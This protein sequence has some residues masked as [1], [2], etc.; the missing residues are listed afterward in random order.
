MMLVGCRGLMLAACVAVVGWLAAPAFGEPRFPPEYQNGDVTKV[1]KSLKANPKLLG[2]WLGAKEDRGTLL[3]CAVADDNVPMAKMLL[4]KGAKVHDAGDE[5]GFTPLHNAKSVAMAGLLISNKA[6]VNRPHVG[7]RTPLHTAILGGR[8][9]VAELLIKKGADVNAVGDHGSPLQYAADWA[10]SAEMVKLLLVNGAKTEI[11]GQQVPE[12]PLELAQNRKDKDS[13]PVKAIIELLS[14][15]ANGT[16]LASITVTD[17]GYTP[18]EFLHW[19]KHARTDK[20]TDILKQNPSLLTAADETGATALHQA[21]AA[22]STEL[23]AV[24]LAHK[25]NVNAQKK[26]G[27]TPLHV[28]AALGQTDAAKALLAKGADPKAKDKQ[29]RTPLSL[30]QQKGYKKIVSALSSGK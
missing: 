6:D 7:G 22:G 9:D 17:P 2:K 4:S 15:V 19:A 14:A 30:A 10:R 12:S 1:S 26:D 11:R 25:A 5:C 27:V 16:D 8:K 18:E 20:V 3:G 28:A 23:I 21:A 13:A 24:L 29:G